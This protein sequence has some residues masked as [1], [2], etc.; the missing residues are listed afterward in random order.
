MDR[1]PLRTRVRIVVSRDKDRAGST[2]G[3]LM[4]EIKDI[5]WRF[6]F[7]KGTIMSI[8]SYC[9]NTVMTDKQKL[10]S[11]LGHIAYTRQEGAL[12]E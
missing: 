11:I 6:G 8:E 10:S 5:H 1:L 7:L 2:G 4:S 9:K 12:N 3:V